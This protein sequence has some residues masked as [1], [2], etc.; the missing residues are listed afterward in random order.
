MRRE[1]LLILPKEQTGDW[2]LKMQWLE[3]CA[4]S[5]LASLLW[6]LWGIWRRETTK[7][8]HRLN[9]YYIGNMACNYTNYTN[10]FPSSLMPTTLCATLRKN[11]PMV[12]WKDP[13]NTKPKSW[14]NRFD[15]L[16]Q[17]ASYTVQV[18]TKYNSKNGEDKEKCFAQCD[19]SAPTKSLKWTLLHEAPETLFRTPKYKNAAVRGTGS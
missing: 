10:H 8:V 11:P 14:D 7:R 5:K 18:K 12:C 15:M 3:E 6:L 4:H 16:C 9:G 1:N 17:K 2:W 13:K 19:H